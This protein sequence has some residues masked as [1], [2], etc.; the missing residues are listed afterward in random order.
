MTVM[1]MAAPGFGTLVG[2]HAGRHELEHQ[3]MTESPRAEI[4][5]QRQEGKRQRRKTVPLW[6]DQW[7]ELTDLAREL[8]DAKDPKEPRITENTLIRIAVD[9]LLEHE[10]HLAGDTE[11][12]IRDNLTAALRGE[13]STPNPTAENS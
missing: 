11:D 5:E 1:E 7:S 2:D 6:V 9:L 3:Q 8:Q 13:G 12:Q 10:H 4:Y